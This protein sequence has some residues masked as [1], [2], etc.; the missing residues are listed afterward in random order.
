MI[1]DSPKF[2]PLGDCYLAVEFGDEADL[3]LNFRVLALAEALRRADLLG[4][5][6]IIPKAKAK[7]TWAS[8]TTSSR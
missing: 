8:S 7:R 3:T 2:R 4:L 6:E 5:I 1:Y